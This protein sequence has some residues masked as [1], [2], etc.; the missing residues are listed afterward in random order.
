MFDPDEGELVAN[1]RLADPT[2]PPGFTPNVEHRRVAAPGS[3]NTLAH[4]AAQPSVPAPSSPPSP[5]FAPPAPA[6]QPTGVPRR[7]NRLLTGLIAAGAAASLTLMGTGWWLNSREGGAGS[8]ISTPAGPA[9]TSTQSDESPAS[10]QE[11]TDQATVE[12]AVEGVW[13]P[14]IFAP[15]VV[16][17]PTRSTQLDSREVL[18]GEF[19]VTLFADPLDPETGLALGY[20]PVQSENQAGRGAAAM[21]AFDLTTGERRWQVDLLAAAGLSGDDEL[22]PVGAILDGAGLVLVYLAVEPEGFAYAA[23]DSQGQVVSTTQGGRG[24]LEAKG[25]V[26]LAIEVP[27]VFAQSLTDLGTEIWRADY[28]GLGNYADPL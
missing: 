12:P 6:P 26:A 8:G 25:G 16:E 4:D 10:E 19:M 28:V 20:T 2:V 5:G 15:D 21:A 27:D 22:G 17:Q 14:P 11:R 7:K 13:S 18:D 23:I 9:Q 3:Q 1:R 24:L